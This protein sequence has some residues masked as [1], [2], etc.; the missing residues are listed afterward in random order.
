MG[1]AYY[2][3]SYHEIKAEITKHLPDTKPDEKGLVTK[4]MPTYGRR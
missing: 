4:N 1:H 2:K 3:I